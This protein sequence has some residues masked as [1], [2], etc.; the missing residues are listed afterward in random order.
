MAIAS[1]ELSLNQEVITEK[2]LHRY[3]QKGVVTHV[4][5]W[6]HTNKEPAKACQGMQIV[7]IKSKKKSE[8]PSY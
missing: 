1:R 2:C 5:T 8:P 7:I 3:I 6:L 4:P